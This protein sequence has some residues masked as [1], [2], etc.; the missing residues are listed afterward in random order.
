[1]RFNDLLRTVLANA[2]QGADSA[3]TRWR[4]CVDLLAQSDVSGADVADA[5]RDHVLDDADR[6]QLLT[7]LGAMRGAVPLQQRAESIIELGS[8]LRSVE[9]VRLCAGDHPVVVCAAMASAHLTDAD[10]TAL[11]PSLGPLGR[12]VLRR[13]TDIGRRARAMLDRFGPV[14]MALPQPSPDTR[15]ETGEVAALRLV[16]RNDAARDARVRDAAA[17]IAMT[18]DAAASEISRI[19]QRIEKF[20]AEREHV[21][22]AQPTGA[23]DGSAK[24]MALARSTDSFA[25]EVDMAGRFVEIIGAPRAAAIGLSI[26][27]PS[28][29]GCTGADGQALG[30]FRRRAAIAGAR[31][32]IEHGYLSGVWRLT[33]EP[34]FDRTSGRFMG[35][36]GYARREQ[37]QEQ[38]VRVSA[39][40]GAVS[41]TSARQLVHEL[42]T[43]LNAIQG[44]AEMIESEMVGPVDSAYRDMARHILSDAHDLTATFDDL[45]LAS[46]LARGD[47][48]ADAR[49]L[50]MAQLAE[51]VVTHFRD[52]GCARID[53][54]VDQA[55]GAVCIDPMQA[56]RMVM[57]LVRAGYGALDE[58]ERLAVQ[59]V[60]AEGGANALLLVDLPRAIAALDEH[61]LLD[62][63]AE[64]ELR[65]EARPP[66]GLAFT[67]RLVRSIVAH[68]GG[69][70]V[71]GQRRISVSL[72]TAAT[73]RGDQ[74]HRR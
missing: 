18:N 73:E 53:L 40:A 58:E 35:Y 57:H 47:D 67:L 22:D 50:D 12:S 49:S 72:P 21:R 37:P 30:A 1:M 69:Q 8:R 14:D 26:G 17:P 2:G 43:P 74:E 48:R 63:D 61:L 31:F 23:A 42:R 15:A 10:W 70:L 46:R 24:P 68:A 62:P 27:L 71:V 19:V 33:A 20:T 38:M 3:V 5:G 39:P 4:Q 55:T 6:S 60:P 7:L 64:V 59:V 44:Y 56:E 52:A 13:R 32:T 36:H 66:L 65:P 51:A 16:A 29:D 25:F 41:A 11:I 28:R 45:D 9:L 34:Q 54:D